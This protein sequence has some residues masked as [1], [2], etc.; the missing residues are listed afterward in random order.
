MV[1]YPPRSSRRGKAKA[2]SAYVLTQRDQEQ[3]A[4]FDALE[5]DRFQKTSK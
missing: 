3:Q 1:L 4:L 2:R 5:L